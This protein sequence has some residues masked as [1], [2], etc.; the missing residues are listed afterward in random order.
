M[1]RRK[2]FFGRGILDTM[3]FV[4]FAHSQDLLRHLNRRRC[5]CH[6]TIN[7]HRNWRPSLVDGCVDD[8]DYNDGAQNDHPIGKLNARYRC[9]FAKPFHDYPAIQT[10]ARQ[11]RSADGRFGAQYCSSKLFL[12]AMAILFLTRGDNETTGTFACCTSTPA[13]AR[14]QPQACAING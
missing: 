4:A 10:A 2:S 7:N 5:G 9:L 12:P 14:A 13:L 3:F 6:A 1:Q 8:Q 11:G